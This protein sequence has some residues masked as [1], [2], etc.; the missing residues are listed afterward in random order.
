MLPIPFHLT[1]H[2][3]GQSGTTPSKQASRPS[4]IS[5][6]GADSPSRSR[7][8]NSRP[9]TTSKLA[10]NVFGDGTMEA[11]S[12]CSS[13]TDDHREGQYHQASHS[14]L[15]QEDYRLRVNSLLSM[16]GVALSSDRKAVAARPANSRSADAVE[17]QRKSTTSAA[18][19]R[20]SRRMAKAEQAFD[21]V[22]DASAPR[23]VVREGLG[24]A[25]DMCPFPTG[26]G[27]LGAA[28]GSDR[29]AARA[30][31]E[32]KGRSVTFSVEEEDGEVAA[33]M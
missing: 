2:V 21:T 8:R 1:Q 10:H 32:S 27:D 33:R 15:A 16:E 23:N 3:H 5:R 14:D 31:R 13:G 4:S 17:V 28:C 7:S 12:S 6:R 22:P 24:V 19:P 20:W 18:K 11:V 29:A 9:F 25:I 30:T 26:Q